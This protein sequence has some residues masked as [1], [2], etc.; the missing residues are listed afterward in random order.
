M[1]VA[2]ILLITQVGQALDVP[3][4][5]VGDAI[6]A[7]EYVF[8]TYQNQKLLPVRLLG[9]V[10]KPGLYH[11]PEQ[12]DI[13]TAL[14]V[15]GGTTSSA[16]TSSIFLSKSDGATTATYDL[17]GLLTTEQKTLPRLNIMDTIY[18]PQRRPLVDPDVLQSATLVSIL[19]GIVVSS[20]IVRN[21]SK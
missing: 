4:V 8:R 1:T 3:S 21:Q 6:P 5:G 19:L 15:A 17:E 13:L 7:T 20:F 16:Q 11:L 9:A 18:V 10:T 12:T 14:S 2:T